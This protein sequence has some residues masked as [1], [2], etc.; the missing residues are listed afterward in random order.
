MQSLWLRTTEE[1]YV[2]KGEKEEQDEEQ[3]EV[4]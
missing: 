4:K 3:D 2:E 1:D